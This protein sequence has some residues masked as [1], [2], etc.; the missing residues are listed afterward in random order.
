[1]RFNELFIFFL[2]WHFFSYLFPYFLFIWMFQEQ[3]T[4]TPKIYLSKHP[5][6]LPCLWFWNNLP[7][8]AAG[9]ISCKLGIRSSPGSREACCTLYRQ[10]DAHRVERPRILP[11]QDKSRIPAAWFPLRKIAYRPDSS[12][13]PSSFLLL[14]R[15]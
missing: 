10:S 7:I 2:F 1:M 11:P 8:A 13:I 15:R 3:F 4:S 12:R 6:S 5:L 14:S 9:S